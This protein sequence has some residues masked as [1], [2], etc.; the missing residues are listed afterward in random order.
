[1]SFIQFRQRVTFVTNPRNLTSPLRR[2]IGMKPIQAE[3]RYNGSSQ[4]VSQFYPLPKN[5]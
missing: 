3:A 2:G 1:M 4:S 5:F